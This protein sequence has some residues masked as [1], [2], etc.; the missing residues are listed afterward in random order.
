MTSPAVTATSLAFA[1][2]TILAVAACA[3]L[4]EPD[5]PGAKIYAQRCADPCHRLY[6]PGSMKYAMWEVMVRRMRPEY[7]P[8]GLPPLTAQEE[9]MILDY[10]RKHAG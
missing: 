8:R 6:L 10:L 7:G 3:R 1:A 2:A 5:S 9:K 4:P